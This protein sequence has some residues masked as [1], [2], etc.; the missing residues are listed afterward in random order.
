[1]VHGDLFPLSLCNSF[2]LQL[3]QSPRQEY[4]SK[5]RNVVNMGFPNFSAVP[6]QLLSARFGDL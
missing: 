6:V 2:F 3:Q 4:S 1:M 5:T